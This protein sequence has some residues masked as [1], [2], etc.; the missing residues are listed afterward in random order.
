MFK[1]VGKSGSWGADKAT[2][3]TDVLLSF[4]NTSVANST[5][6][7]GGEGCCAMC[8]VKCE[9]HRAQELG[10]HAL[11]QSFVAI[12]NGISSHIIMD[13]QVVRGKKPMPTFVCH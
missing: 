1:V 9:C 12:T 13:L 4:T 11:D 2:S 5:A 8:T 6:S 7:R 3:R 10:L